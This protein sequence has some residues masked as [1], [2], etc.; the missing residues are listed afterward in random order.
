[1]VDGEG[2]KANGRWVDGYSLWIYVTR[3]KI[4]LIPMT[5]KPFQGLAQDLHTIEPDSQ[6]EILWGGGG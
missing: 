3:A 6:H 1:M 4:E 5:V 2:E